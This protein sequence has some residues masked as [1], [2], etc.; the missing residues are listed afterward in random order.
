[1]LSVRITG[2]DKVQRELEE[3]Q[4]R[5]SGKLATADV[6]ARPRRNVGDINLLGGE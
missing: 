5:A 4:Q 2:L 1:M 3:A 6:S